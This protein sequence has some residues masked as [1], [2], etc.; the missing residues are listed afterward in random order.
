MSIPYNVLLN[1]SC[2]SIEKTLHIIFH[3]LCPDIVILGLQMQF[4]RDIKHAA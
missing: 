4:S 3:R 1:C 2:Q